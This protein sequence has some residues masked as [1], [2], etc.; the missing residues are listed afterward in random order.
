MSEEITV[1]NITISNTWKVNEIVDFVRE[2]GVS[3]IPDY[4]QVFSLS[5]IQ[6]E[7]PKLIEDHEKNYV[8]PINYPA[9]RAVVVDRKKWS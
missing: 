7:F 8:R 5:T 6:E 3:V 2:Y 4:L 1:A 9:G